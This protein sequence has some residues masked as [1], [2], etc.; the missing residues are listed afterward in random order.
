MDA[1][2]SVSYT[3]LDVYKRQVCGYLLGLVAGYFEGVVDRVIMCVMDVLFAFP[4]ILLAIFI[5]AVLGLSL[6]HI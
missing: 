2:P 3:H 1:I 5:S 4:S 6:I